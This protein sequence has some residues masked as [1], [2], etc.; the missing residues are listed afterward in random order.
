DFAEMIRQRLDE[1][2]AV[3]RLVNTLR[4]RVF[5]IPAAA[6][7]SVRVATVSSGQFDDGKTSPDRRLCLSGMGTNSITVRD[8]QSGDVV[9]SIPNAHQL[10]IRDLRWSGD[11]Q[12]FV[13]A[14]ADGRAI[15][16]NLTLKTN[17]PPF[18][19]PEPVYHAELNGRGTVLLTACRDKQA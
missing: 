14:S 17:L 4:R 5:L 10:V 19:H 15:I 6:T 16:W 18:A 13:S 1:R 2:V 9:W 3:E 12:H 8:C 7:N 11:S